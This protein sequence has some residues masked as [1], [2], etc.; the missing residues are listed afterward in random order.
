[1]LLAAVLS[2]ATVEM[3]DM[4]SS[5]APPLQMLNKF[6]A[7]RW[8]FRTVACLILGGQVVS[9]IVKGARSSKCSSSSS[10]GTAEGKAAGSS[11]SGKRATPTF[12]EATC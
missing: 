2:A 5:A 6:N 8:L 7:P 11:S 9:R 12:L 3:L 1:M 10:P 4:A